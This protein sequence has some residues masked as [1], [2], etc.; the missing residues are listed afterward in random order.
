MNALCAFINS[1]GVN[2]VVTLVA[3]II[4]LAGIAVGSVLFFV[5]RRKRRF[6]LIDSIRSTRQSI[7]NGHQV[8][9]AMLEGFPT[10][11]LL[12]SDLRPYLLRTMRIDQAMHQYEEWYNTIRKAAE[13]SPLNILGAD[14]QSE[15]DT[16]LD[17]LDNLEESI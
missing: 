9:M 17:H 1:T 16:T 3:I 14:C 2:T 6:A 5:Q 15:I 13:N 12:V 7:Q 10:H 4:G 8:K 11:K